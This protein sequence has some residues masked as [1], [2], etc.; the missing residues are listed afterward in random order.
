MYLALRC[1]DRL[2]A[3][4]R[5][6]LGFDGLFLALG[7]VVEFDRKLLV[8]D[9]TVFPVGFALRIRNIGLVSFSKFTDGCC[10]S[11]HFLGDKLFSRYHLDKALPCSLF[12]SG[13]GYE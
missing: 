9:D 6:D 7:L 3:G 8:V 1:E 4:T 13:H 5:N 10:F 12:C 11:C 2:T